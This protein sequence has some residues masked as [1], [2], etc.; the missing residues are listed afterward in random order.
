MIPDA[1][2]RKAALFELWDEA[3]ETGDDRLVTAGAE[4]RMAV[5]GCIRARFPA[6]GATAFTAS[7]ITAFNARRRSKQPFAP[8]E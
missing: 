3:A 1:A 2:G 7:E 8:Y 6:S 4:A 5:L